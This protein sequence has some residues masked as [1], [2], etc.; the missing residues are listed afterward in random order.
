MMS[1]GPAIRVARPNLLEDQKTGDFLEILVSEVFSPD[2]FFIQLKQPGD[3]YNLDDLLDEMEDVYSVPGG[4]GTG[5]GLHLSSKDLVPD[6]HCAVRLA[7]TTKWYRAAVRAQED[8]VVE[9][10]LLDFGNIAAV[11]SSHQYVR[12]LLKQFS[13]AMP[14][15][16]V[17]ARL[18]LVAPPG[19]S[20]WPEESSELLLELVSKACRGEG[21]GL[22]AR[23]EGWTEDGRVVLRL[24]DTVTN[25]QPGGL[26]IGKELVKEGLANW[27]A[28]EDMYP[29]S[30]LPSE[31]EQAERL[32]RLLELVREVQ[33]EMSA[34]VVSGEGRRL[35]VEMEEV[36]K[37]YKK[38]VKQV[39]DN[40]ED[41]DQV[42]SEQVRGIGVEVNEMQTIIPGQKSLQKNKEPHNQSLKQ[43]IE[44]PVQSLQLSRCRL[45]L[46]TWR[47]T[48]WVT[49]TEASLLVPVWR[50]WDLL[51]QVL[52]RRK[53]DHTPEHLR[54]REEQ[55]LWQRLGQSG[56][57]GLVG[58][59]GKEVDQLAMYRVEEL[60]AILD[61]LQVKVEEEDLVRIRAAAGGQDNCW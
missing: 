8:S 38:L 53:S 10:F 35:V 56:V 28:V 16:A 30:A 45:H 3:I 37:K 26:D 52:V 21:G 11:P 36:G 58:R 12:R 25:T 4:P 59:N 54:A 6:L 32:E 20:K 39:L 42:N 13:S 14:A 44:D 29:L 33:E 34:M 48:T 23:L 22:V 27:R 60:P 43:T 40:R 5:P 18:G 49:S 15:Q 31:R 41:Y 19:G 1:F 47:D 51:A 2:R 7:D 24:F 55:T 50:G 46:I 61:V 9:V 17:K 57:K